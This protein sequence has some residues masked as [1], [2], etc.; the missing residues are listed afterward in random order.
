MTAALR[1]ASLRWPPRAPPSTGHREAGNYQHEN[2]D[3]RRRHSHE[4][5]DLGLGEIAGGGNGQVGGF[6]PVAL[7]I[8]GQDGEAVAEGP[9][10]VQER[11]VLE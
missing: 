9:C 4:E 2:D 10:R 5:T 11:K 7:V 6:S 3:H 8:L 1:L